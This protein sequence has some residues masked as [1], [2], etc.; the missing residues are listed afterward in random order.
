[1][2]TTFSNNSPIIEFCDRNNISGKNIQLGFMQMLSGAMSA[3]RNPN[4]HS[5]DNVITED[6]CVRRLMFAS[7]L[8]YKIDDGVSY[9]NIEE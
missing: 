5:N 3:L 1:M 9:C 7:M 6:D 8:M 4:T 2:T